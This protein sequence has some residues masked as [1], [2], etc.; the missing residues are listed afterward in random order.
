MTAARA[1]Q[2]RVLLISGG[3]L[4]LLATLWVWTTAVDRPLTREYAEFV[5]RAESLSAEERARLQATIQKFD[6]S[7]AWREPQPYLRLVCPIAAA[8]CF[9]LAF[10][11]QRAAES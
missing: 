6:R 2:L 7:G 10:R 11:R 8:V 3:L 4:S 9:L 5:Q 1:K